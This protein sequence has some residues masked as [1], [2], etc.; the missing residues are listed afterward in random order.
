M[1]IVIIGA[2]SGCFGASQIRDILL[3]KD[4]RSR[5]ITL[6]LVDLD[7]DGLD[8][9]AT[10]ADMLK[11]ETGGDAR[12]E[13]HTD[14]RAALG[15]ADYVFVS[16]AR[17]R[18]PLW[19]QDFRVPLS[20]GFR[21]CLGENGGPGAVFHA[22]RSFELL[23]P[24]C[25]DVEELAPNALV[26]NFTNPE[27]KVLHAILTLTRV[28]AVGL[29]HG[30]FGT[31]SLLSK[32]LDRPADT[33]RVTSAGINHFFSILK[34]EDLKTGGDL[35]PLAKKTIL[36][37]DQC[38]PPIFRQILRIFDVLSFPSDDHI[39]EYLAYGSE[40][41]G[42]KWAY[43]QEVRK[44]SPGKEKK[45]LDLVDLFFVKDRPE[46]VMRPSG[47]LAVPIIVDI[48]LNRGAF[49]EAVNVLNKGPL[50]SN[51][52][53]DAAVEVPAIAD[54]G[55]IHP[56]AVGALPEPFAEH[57]RR[58]CTISRLLTEAYRTRD[59]K[60]LLQALLL[61]PVVNNSTSAE[62]MMDEML[63]LQADFLPQF[64]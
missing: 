3:C 30:V 52:P 4:L 47:E 21:H 26:L 45:G 61:D 13:K 35:L 51:L 63:K 28:K 16:V 42:V 29:C 62:K 19:E 57:L 50:I 37:D 15:G 39:G 20:H 2:G 5:G 24:I 41:H 7:P 46:W 34:I 49:R 55:G 36:A 38:G 53:A 32:V 6:S 1:K 23:I 54:A 17:K 9:S 11:K 64:S 33:F 18:Y 48:L 56:V 12:I 8:R 59:R 40:F 25:R 27:M 31:V 44:V 22:L 14:R 10:L 60:L 43:G 58:Q